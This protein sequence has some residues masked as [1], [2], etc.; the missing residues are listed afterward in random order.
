LKALLLHDIQYIKALL[1]SSIS[2]EEFRVGDS[3]VAIELC[4][5]YGMLLLVHGPM[6]ALPSSYDWSYVVD[7]FAQKVYP[8]VQSATTSYSP[9]SSKKMEMRCVETKI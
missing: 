3:F 5:P 8:Q 7:K 9:P 4:A 2:N 6:E 1:S